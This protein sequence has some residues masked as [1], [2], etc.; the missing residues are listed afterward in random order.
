MFLRIF[1]I[2]SFFSLFL[3]YPQFATSETLLDVDFNNHRSG[4][5]YGYNDVRRD[6]TTR[7]GTPTWISYGVKKGNVKVVGGGKR[8]NA[9]EVTYQKGRYAG[10]TGASWKARFP[11]KKEAYLSYYMY[12]PDNFSTKTYGRS[13]RVEGGKL[14]GLCAR[15]CPSGGRR[16]TTDNGA[17]FRFM[18][19]S[20][21][22]I[23][24]YVYDLT[25]SKW[26]RHGEDIPLRTGLSKGRWLKLVQR[27]KMND[28]W[29]SNGEIDVWLDGKHV[30]GVRG[31]KFRTKSSVSI[32]RLFFSTF[33]GG[34]D[35]K[36]APT[37]TQKIR[38]DEFEVTT[39]KPSL[40]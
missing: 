20:W 6:F 16:I 30:K 24:L 21:P 19:R 33:F 14:P 31:R 2:F 35:W 23:G 11:G 5:T 12:F 3:A 40:R 4:S 26:K 37:R 27:V 34:G 39:H 36:W 28:P 9:I 10:G 22:W 25:K 17:S 13:P 29:R 1:S 38:F 7:A 18:F 32:D 8:G 15:G